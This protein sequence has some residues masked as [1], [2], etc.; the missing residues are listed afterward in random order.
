EASRIDALSADAHKF[1]LGPEGV[2]IFYVSRRAMERVNP[3]VVGWLSVDNPED[4]LNYEQPFAPSAKRFESAALNTA[5]VVGLGAAIELFLQVGVEQIERY[6]LDLGDYL[7]QRLVDRG[8]HV[9]SSRRE[10]EKSAVI[11]CQH[12]RY[13]PL[14]LYH[15]LNDRRI[16]S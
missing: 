3:T 11:C 4:Y 9:A 5:G 13:L 8:Y 2:S 6:L 7:C 16:I 10:G 1:L 12:E 14:E 15:L